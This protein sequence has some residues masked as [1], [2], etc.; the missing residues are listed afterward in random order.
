MFKYLK[1]IFTLALTLGLWQACGSTAMAQSNFSRINKPFDR[2]TFSPYLNLFRRGNGPVSNYFGVVRPQQ[3][4]YAQNEEFGEELEGIQSRQK[5]SQNPNERRRRIPGVYTLG[6]TG[7]AVGFNTIRPN[8]SGEGGGSGP[9]LSGFNAPQG[10]NQFGGDSGQSS[11]GGANGGANFGSG[12]G[13][14]SG[15]GAGSGFG[16]GGGRGY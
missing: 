7:H 6:V 11:F 10:G 8:G 15:F 2:P 3:Q 4:F 16:S 5:Q 1:L 12:F 14:N 13:S 9:Q